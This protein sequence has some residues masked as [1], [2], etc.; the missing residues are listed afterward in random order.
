[1][2]AKRDELMHITRTAVHCE[3]CRH[4]GPIWSKFMRLH[5]MPLAGPGLMVSMYTHVVTVRWCCYVR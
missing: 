3:R 2:G 4:L 1:M 5:C